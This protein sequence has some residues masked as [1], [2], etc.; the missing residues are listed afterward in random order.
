MT[1]KQAQVISIVNQKGGVMKT[2]LAVNIAAIAAEKGFR[3]LLVDADPQGNASSLFYN[4]F[5]DKPNFKPPKERTLKT[6]FEPG[7]LKCS[8]IIHQTRIEN[9]FLA[10][11]GDAMAATWTMSTLLESHRRIQYFLETP[12]KWFDLIVIDTQ[13]DLSV[14]TINALMASNWLLVPMPPELFAFDGFFDILNPTIEMVSPINNELQ[15]LGIVCTLYQ[16]NLKS[17]KGWVHSLQAH[18]TDKFLGIIHAAS[19]VKDATDRKLTIGEHDRKS[20]AYREL[21]SLTKTICDLIHLEKRGEDD[22]YID[23]S[24]YFADPRVPGYAKQPPKHSILAAFH[25]QNKDAETDED[26]IPMP[27]DDNEATLEHNSSQISHKAFVK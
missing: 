24:G 21:L 5:S 15:L 19:T 27:D 11:G 23:L 8:Q 2:T 13:P 12:K 26:E 14:Y 17:H 9:L 20:R 25:R 1:T 16:G 18:F 6:L 10:P 4:D 22:P 3:V 7:I